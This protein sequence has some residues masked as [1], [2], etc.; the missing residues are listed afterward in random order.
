VTAQRAKA[1][2]TSAHFI[3][4]IVCLA[5]SDLPDGSKWDHELKLD[6]Y[7]AIAVKKCG[8]IFLF[9]RN[10]RDFT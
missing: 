4:P 6:G 8:R 9:S 7:R 10:G 1:E 5:V 2:H 3:E